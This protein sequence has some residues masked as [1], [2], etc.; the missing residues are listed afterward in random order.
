MIYYTFQL[1]YKAT[2]VFFFIYINLFYT[3][4]SLSWISRHISFIKSFNIVSNLTNS[5][6]FDCD[7]LGNFFSAL[8]IE[9]ILFSIVF[10][11]CNKLLYLFFIDFCLSFIDALVSPIVSGLVSGLV[12]SFFLVSFLIYELNLL[13]LSFF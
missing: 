9:S 3:F 11:V 5:I 7:S 1:I 2:N 12:L 13:T 8:Y 4:L 10:L 6:S